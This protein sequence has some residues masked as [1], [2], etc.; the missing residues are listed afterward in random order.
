MGELVAKPRGDQLTTARPHRVGHIDFALANPAQQLIEHCVAYGEVLI[1]DG[2]GGLEIEC[3]AGHGV[4]ILGDVPSQHPEELLFGARE[5]IKQLDVRANA[6]ATLEDAA[7]VGVK[8]AAGGRCRTVAQRARYLLVWKAAE[9]GPIDRPAVRR[10]P[11]RGGD[12]QGLSAT[13]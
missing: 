4:A 6:A 7:G 12:S 3:V 10:V 13:W 9:L 8:G 11:A 2:I 1:A 5:R